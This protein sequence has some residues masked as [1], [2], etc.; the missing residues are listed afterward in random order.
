MKGF[1]YQP[2]EERGCPIPNT[3]RRLSQGHKLW[4]QMQKHY[5]VPEDFRTFLNSTI[6]TLRSVTFILQK[7]KNNIP[8]FNA[9]YDAWREKMKSDKVMNWL[10]DARTT[11]VHIGDLEILSTA[12]IHV[13][14][15]QTLTSMKLKIPPLMPTQSISDYVIDNLPRGFITNIGDA[16]LSIERKWIMESIAEF[17]LLEALAHAFTF[18]SLIVKEAHNLAGYEYISIDKDDKSV[19]ISEER[20]PCMISTKEIR[21]ERIDLSDRNPLI[22]QQATVPYNAEKVE[23]SLKRYGLKRLSEINSDA[24]K[25]AEELVER[26][27][28]VLKKDGYHIR[29]IYFHFQNQ[30]I[31]S[32]ICTTNRTEKY[33]M[34]DVLANEVRRMKADALI[35]IGEVWLG[36][37]DQYN[38]GFLPTEDPKHTEALAVSVLTASGKYKSFITPFTKTTSGIIVLEKT[39]EVNSTPYHLAAIYKVWGLPLPTDKEEKIN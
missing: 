11:I 29:L 22:L 9:W 30:W 7:E 32:G 33:A 24:F 17:E 5:F 6:D 16:V 12:E 28:T 8:D 3:H 18:L 23:K 37:L 4:H 35:E 36:S 15:N 10:S 21:T 14:N 34:M 13:H 39:R 38:K 2:E 20:L 31:P 25:F 1:C 19:S 26:A 27:K